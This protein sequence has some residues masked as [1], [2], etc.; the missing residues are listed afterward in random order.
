MSPEAPVPVV[1]VTKKDFRLGGAANVAL[2]IKAMGANPILC[3][4]I[5]D[6]R[7]GS[8]FASR[9]A[10]RDITSEGIH[11]CKNRPTTVKTRVI[12]HDKHIVRIDEESTAVINPDEKEGLIQNIEKLLPKCQVV[13]FEDYDKGC[14]TPEIISLTVDLAK[15]HNIPTVVD[16]KREI[17]LITKK[18]PCSNLT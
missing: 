17:F 15:K 13:I 4:I 7:D 1:S 9:L 16:P 6:D 18:Y 12:S 5:G 8:K 10:E 2:N 14:I 11:K 3:S